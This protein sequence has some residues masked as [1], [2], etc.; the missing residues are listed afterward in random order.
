MPTSSR[1]ARPWPARSVRSRAR[2]QRQQVGHLVQQRR[3]GFGEFHALGRAHE[4]RR[5]EFV[6]QRADLPRQR[7]LRH[8]QALGGAVDVAFLG[9]GEEVAHLSQ[10]HGHRLLR[11]CNT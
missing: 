11:S 5:A 9:H 8:V 2:R 1:P 10:V 4:E 3:A 6:F 7:R